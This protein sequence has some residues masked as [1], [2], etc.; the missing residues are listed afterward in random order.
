MPSHPW[1]SR[2][3]HD[4]VKRALWPARDLLDAGVP[5]TAAEAAAL[6]A[7]LHDLIAPDGSPATARELWR[8]FR[9]DAPATVPAAAL[10][11]FEQALED[12][13]TA[14]DSRPPAEAAQVVLRLEPAFQDLARHVDAA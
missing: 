13:A 11:A 5:P 10:D 14:V 6:R 7:G 9:A 1:V 8:R 3:R 2:L 4:L 12:A